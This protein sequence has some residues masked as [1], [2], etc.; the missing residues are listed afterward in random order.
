MA[1]LLTCQR[2]G[3]PAI[4]VLEG[5][6]AEPLVSRRAAS[7]ATASWDGFKDPVT[8]INEARSAT[9][10]DLLFFWFDPHQGC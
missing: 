10:T 2:H 9:A 3:C 7:Q 5:P 8:Q 4:V 1:Y 6:P